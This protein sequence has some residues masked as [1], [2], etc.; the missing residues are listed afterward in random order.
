MSEI[1]GISIAVIGSGYWGKNLVRDFH[2][3]GALGAIV[4]VNPDVSNA[5]VAQYGCRALTLEEA[6]NDPAISGV[7]IAVPAEAHF[8]IASQA[9]AAGKHVYVEKPL[10]LNV[11]DGEALVK[12]SAATGMQLMVGHLLQ[13]NSAFI[14]LKAFVASGALGKLTYVYSNRLSYGI[15]RSEEDV[16][17]SLAPHDF[18][19]ILSLAGEEPSSVSAF[20][21]P[22]LLPTTGDFCQVHLNFA[23]GLKA[24]VFCSWLNPFKEQ[25]LVVVGERGAVV[26]EDSAKNPADKLKYYAHSVEWKDGKPRAVKAVDEAGVPLPYEPSNTLKEECRHFLQIIATGKPARTD[27][28]EAMICKK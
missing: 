16:L 24:H 11:K 6:L 14:A 28:P 7:A 26:F 18:S 13:Y 10:A 19:M 23:S 17:W 27:G 12:M 8:E 25:R 4:E 3:L 22:T 1:S 2:G 5:I 20:S 15:L 9:L 21:A